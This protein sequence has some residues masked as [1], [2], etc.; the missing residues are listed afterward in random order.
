M[1][2]SSAA[3][4]WSDHSR[5]AAHAFWCLVGFVFFALILLTLT[6]LSAIE[7]EIGYEA[8]L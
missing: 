6:N 1:S 2:R 4:G 7:L 5:F 3:F 8:F